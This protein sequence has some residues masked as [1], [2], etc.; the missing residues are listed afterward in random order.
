MV[1]LECPC[2]GFARQSVHY[3]VPIFLFARL[4]FLFRFHSVFGFVFPPRS[5]QRDFVLRTNDGATTFSSPDDTRRFGRE[6]RRQR[7]IR[8]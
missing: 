5:F 6:P 2:V 8:S 4:A 3:V 1:L 7:V